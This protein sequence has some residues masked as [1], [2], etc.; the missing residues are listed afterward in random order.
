MSRLINCTKCGKPL[1]SGAAPGVEL[2]CP[3]CGSKFTAGSDAARGAAPAAAALKPKAARLVVGAVAAGA[4]LFSAA[5]FLWPG[6]LRTANPN[7]LARANQEQARNLLAFAPPESNIIVG[8]NFGQVRKSPDLQFAWDKFKRWLAQSEAIPAAVHDLIADAD[9]ALVAGSSDLSAALICAVSTE[10]PID[11]AKLRHA[12]DA[13]PPQQHEGVAVFACAPIAGRDAAL[14]FPSD[15]VA[16][17]GLMSSEALAQRVSSATHPQVHPDLRSQVEQV[18]GSVIWAA[19]QFDPPMKERLR[20]LE[21]HLSLALI[22]VPEAKPLVPLVQR[23]K[24]TVLSLDARGDQKIKL[25]LGFTCHDINDA[26]ALRSA[27]LNLWISRGK[28][29]LELAAGLADPNHA[30][31]LGKLLGE[32]SQTFDLEQRETSVLLSIEVNQATLDE[33]LSSGLL[34]AVR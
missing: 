16:V 2:M 27:V 31:K 24:G 7:P 15:N 34:P 26:A 29:L 21:K 13:G 18:S 5:A 30:G 23:G 1:R 11:A 25:S 3:T 4:A 17:L 10:H 8:V 20:Q 22:F 12:A 19:L 6:F 33:L 32:V 28:A 14:A 9:R